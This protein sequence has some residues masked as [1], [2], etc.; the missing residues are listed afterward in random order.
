MLK[1]T[2]RP[3]NPDPYAKLAK[4]NRVRSITLVMF[5]LFR[6]FGLWTPPQIGL[7]WRYNNDAQPAPSHRWS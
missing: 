2:F 7:I 3:Y 1:G 6:T 5:G 4:G